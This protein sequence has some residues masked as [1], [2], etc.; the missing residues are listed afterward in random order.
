MSAARRI[1]V[2]SPLPG[3]ALDAL[4]AAHNVVVL[5]TASA[6]PTPAQLHSAMR[7]ADALLCMLTDPVPREAIASSGRLRV[8]GN[9]A[10]GYDNIDVPAATELGVQ[11]VN[12]PNVLT[13][14]T[15]DLAWAL[16]L[17]AARRIAEADRFVRARRF[18]GWRLDLLLG[19]PLRGRTLGI[20]GMGRIGRAIAERAQGFGL[21]VLYT[22]R[23]QLDP[24]EEERLG[25]RYVDKSTLLASSDFLALSLPA[26]PET[27]HWLDRT[28][29]AL[30]EPGAVVVNTG[31]GSTV[32]EA[33]LAEALESGQIAAAGLDVFEREPE[34]DARLL[35]LDN[36]VLAPH[37]GSATDETRSAMAQAVAGDILRVLAGQA[38]E[39]PV[40]RPA[41]SS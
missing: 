28:A 22:Q 24:A 27:R 23:H 37:I 34:I 41:R 30:L 25:A 5:G 35:A 2:T 31:R 18:R 21:L 17:A 1:V 26:S 6:G 39:H 4:R 11:V 36:V 40:N 38:P 8:I 29:I 7:D 12:T 9:C 33:A 14:A 20:A 10:V 19:R 3:G 16:L 13:D 15:A 32:D